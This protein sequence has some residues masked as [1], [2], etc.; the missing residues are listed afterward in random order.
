M[1][2]PQGAC[3][4]LPHPL[5]RHCKSQLFKNIGCGFGYVTL[6][7]FSVYMSKAK[8]AFFGGLAFSN[9]PELFKIVLIGW[10]K[11]K[12]PIKPLLFRASQV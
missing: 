1:P 7:L 6:S 9:Q 3:P 2:A 10:K 4:H 11:A 5:L 12:P 8:V